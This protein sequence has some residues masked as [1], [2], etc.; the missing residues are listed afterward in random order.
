MTHALV[1]RRPPC[2]VRRAAVEL[3]D[4]I[5]DRCC[6]LAIDIEDAAAVPG[7]PLAVLTAELHHLARRLGRAAGPVEQAV[8]V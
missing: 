3:L 8:T 4:E 1:R 6:G 2:P 5:A 7:L